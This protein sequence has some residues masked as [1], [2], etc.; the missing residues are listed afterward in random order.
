MGKIDFH[1]CFNPR[2]QRIND[3][4]HEISEKERELNA[5]KKQVP[6]QLVSDGFDICNIINDYYRSLL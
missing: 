4:T 5:L 1:I 3:L 6:T 2:E